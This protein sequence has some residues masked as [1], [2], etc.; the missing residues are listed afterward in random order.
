MLIL[1]PHHSRNVLGRSLVCS[2]VVMKINEFLEPLGWGEVRDK[3]VLPEL[4]FF[5]LS[6]FDFPVSAMGE[7]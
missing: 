6:H 3:T 5:G 1:V 4:I 7:I 2:L